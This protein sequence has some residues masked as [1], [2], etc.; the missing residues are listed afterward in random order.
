[1]EDSAAT[2]I[3]GLANFKQGT[4]PVG[5][6]KASD[7]QVRTLFEHIYPVGNNGAN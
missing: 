2:T 1:M 7:K 4:H 6:F 5:T 3:A